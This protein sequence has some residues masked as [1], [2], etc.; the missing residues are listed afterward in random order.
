MAAFCVTYQ[1][2]ESNVSSS[3]PTPNTLLAESVGRCKMITGVRGHEI[4]LE[5]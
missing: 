3:K 5:E 1:A 2:G 4:C